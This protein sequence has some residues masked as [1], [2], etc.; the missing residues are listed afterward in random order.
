MTSLSIP[1]GWDELEEPH[2]DDGIVADADTRFLHTDGT[3]IVIWSGVVEDASD[4]SVEDDDEYAVEVYDPAGEYVE[5][6]SLD[7]DQAAREAA[8]TLMKQ[9]S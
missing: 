9:H 4:Y 1:S 7:S 3:E 6:E 2:P 5:G 8:H